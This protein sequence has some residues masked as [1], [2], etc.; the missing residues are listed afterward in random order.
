MKK[1]A[2]IIVSITAWLF[3]LL[4]IFLPGVSNAAETNWH[5]NNPISSG[6]IYD[7]VALVF[8]L[9]FG[10]VAIVA[11][12]YLV[13]GGFNYVTAGGNPEAIEAAKVTITNAI[14]GLVLVLI[15]YLLIQFLLQQIG[16]ADYIR[17]NNSTPPGS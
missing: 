9:A 15:S 14:I 3:I 4:I 11:L 17:I 7:V 6:N 5:I 16:A 2:F 12:G 13:M 8:N 10:V 1:K